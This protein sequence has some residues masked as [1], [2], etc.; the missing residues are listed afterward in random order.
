LYPLYKNPNLIFAA[1]VSR[2]Y[3]SLLIKVYII[4]GIPRPQIKRAGKAIPKES[5]L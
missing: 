4:A 5:V 3:F 2:F 1:S